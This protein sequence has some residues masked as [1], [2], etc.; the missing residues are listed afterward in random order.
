MNTDQIVMLGLSLV[1]TTVISLVGFFIRGTLADFKETLRTLRLDIN[2][3]Q[4]WKSEH[5]MHNKTNFRTLKVE[6]TRCQDNIKRIKRR[7]NDLET[8]DEEE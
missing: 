4:S 3:I 5:S 1:S 8:E 7:L 2:D 6:V